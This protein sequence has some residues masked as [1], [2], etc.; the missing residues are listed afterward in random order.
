ME[1]HS[2]FTDMPVHRVRQIT[3]PGTAE[4]RRLSLA[5]DTRMKELRYVYR[6]QLPGVRGNV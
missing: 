5:H 4:A 6:R 2:E 1:Y 3:V